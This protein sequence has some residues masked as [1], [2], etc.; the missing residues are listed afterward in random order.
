MLLAT[1][2]FILVSV[3]IS[4]ICFLTTSNVYISIALFLIYVAYY[5]IFLRKRFVKFYSIINRAHS[6]YFFI[7]SFI[8]TMSVKE[9]YEEAFSS[10]IRIE[11]RNLHTYAK[12]LESLA[13]GEKTRYL[14]SYFKLSIYKMFI[15]IL[16]I[17]DEQGGNILTMT[18]NIIKEATR[19]EKVLS[20]TVSIGYKHLFEF[21]TLWLLSFGILLFMRFGLSDFYKIMLK[22]E[23]FIPMLSV[24]FL[25]NLVSV[26]LFFQSFTNLTIKEDIL[27]WKSWN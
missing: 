23:I 12:E 24:F 6:C 25:F 13:P 16:D 9:S 18:D 22:S 7:N 5:Y 1:A 15:N 20:E 27:E 4:L 8:V 17:Y 11:D 3:L 26:H 2:C 10:G 21:I 19:M 14:R